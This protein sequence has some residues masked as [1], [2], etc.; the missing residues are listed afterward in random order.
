MARF[1]PWTFLH[2][3]DFWLYVQ[4]LFSDAMGSRIGILS[5]DT[6]T[7]GHELGEAWTKPPNLEFIDV[8]PTD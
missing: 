7:R 5:S 6:S 8:Y 1:L 4:L 3:N 2:K